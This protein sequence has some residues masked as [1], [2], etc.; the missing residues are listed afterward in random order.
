VPAP[1]PDSIRRE[2]EGIARRIAEDL[3]YIGVLAVELFLEKRGNG[4]R[5]LVNEIAPRVHNSGHWT[6]EACAISQFENHIR[7]V[8]G[9]PLGS[10]ARHSDARM[11]NL[12]GEDI[13]RALPLMSEDASRSVHL[14]GKHETRPGRKMGHYV[15][16]HPSHGR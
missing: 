10:A 14:Y 9:W 11:V 2:A 6:I 3:D 13:G 15:E 8:A 4:H 7:A 5:L 1:I 12:L 16:L